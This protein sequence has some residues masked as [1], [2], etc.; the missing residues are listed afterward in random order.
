M[1]ISNTSV[2][3]ENWKRR[4]RFEDDVWGKNWEAPMRNRVPLTNNPPIWELKVEV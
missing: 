2:Q 3:L 1:H 4:K